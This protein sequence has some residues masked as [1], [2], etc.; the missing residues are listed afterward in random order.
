M[1]LA[2]KITSI[3]SAAAMLASF[4]AL[5]VDAAGKN[6][7][8]VSYETLTQAVETSDGTVIPAGAVAATV[9]VAGNTGFDANTIVIDVPINASVCLNDNGVPTV[10]SGSVTSGAIFGSAVLNNALCVTLASGEQCLGN[11]DVFTIYYI[12]DD[13]NFADA[14][15]ISSINPATNS[16]Q[17]SQATLSP[18][19]TP[20]QYPTEMGLFALYG[21]ANDNNMVDSVDASLILS[22]LESHNTLEISVASISTTYSNYFS[23]AVCAKEPDA[24]DTGYIN[25]ADASLILSFASCQGLGIPY[26]G[27]YSDKV[28]Q[29]FL[30]SN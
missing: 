27:E 3:A 4:A 2:K 10:S 6:R 9:S 25:S 8:S 7:Y 17:P 23:H 11:G 29:L 5:N 21:D 1:K 26:T 20:N 13:S 30:V 14:P 22:T 16:I 24:N 28:G 12:S 15:S 18:V 19:L